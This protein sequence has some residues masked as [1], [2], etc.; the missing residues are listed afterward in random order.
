MTSLDSA[1]VERA[2]EAAAQEVFQTMLDLEILPLP[3]G[4]EPGQSGPSEG[5]VS[6]IGL[7]GAWV[8]TGCISCSPALACRLASRMLMSEFAAVDEEVLDAIA[9]IT[10]MIIGNVKTALEEHLGPLG[11]SIPTVIYG[12]NFT[13]KSPGHSRWIVI[14]LT[15]DTETFTVRVCLAPNRQPD[16]SSRPGRSHPY[17]ILTE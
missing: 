9:E 4:E 10:N 15:C 11:L 13:T 1:I 5:V 2:T 7:A 8:G 16:A 14:P 3:A 12:R 17:T 6:L